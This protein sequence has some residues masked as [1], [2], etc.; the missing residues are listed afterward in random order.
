M[1]QF[2]RNQHRDSKV[3]VTQM[4]LS[5]ADRDERSGPGQA[6]RQSVYLPPA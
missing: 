6:E 4:G 3:V 1:P 5:N 2:T